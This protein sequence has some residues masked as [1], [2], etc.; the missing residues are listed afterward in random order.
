MMPVAQ[1]A[2]VAWHTNEEGHRLES[3]AAEGS[4]R[5]LIHVRRDADLRELCTL[6]ADAGFRVDCS[7]TERVD[8]IHSS[9]LATGPSLT[10]TSPHRS[11]IPPLHDLLILDQVSALAGL[12]SV[13]TR[14]SS[15]YLDS[16][17]PVLFITADPNARL[18]GLANGANACLVR[19]FSPEELLAQVRALLRLKEAHNRLSE[20][21][22]E[23]HRANKR[24][25][26]A[27]R[28]IDEELELARRIQQSM[29]PKS[30]PSL[31]PAKFA[32]YYHPCGRVGGDFY[33]V[34]RLDEDHLG[35]Y[36]A[37][38][39]GHGIPAALLTIFLKKAIQAKEIVGTHYRLLP[40]GEV[41][42]RLNREMI[43]LALAESPFLTM[44]YALYD[45]RDSTV[46]FSRAGHP[47]PLYLPSS[48]ELEFWALHGTLLGVFETEFAVE[49]RRMNPGDKLLLYTDGIETNDETENRQGAL[50]LLAAAAKHRHRPIAELITQLSRELFVE[51]K[52]ADD[53]TLLGMEVGLQ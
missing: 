24:L 17:V 46:S 32:V 44:I 53:L 26:H 28:Q 11:T 38:V 5:I 15:A 35:F 6:L 19:P 49:K 37:D 18:D 36:V 25:T 22:D 23:F 34:T 40:P 4:Y 29:L 21:T 8:S 20:K 7:R 50:R 3:M 13:A 52:Q 16:L 43:Q 45:R 9:Q 31:P 41:L 47:P 51:G 12:R 42:V 39:M 10:A 1:S 2:L 33:D 14:L 27:Y 30:F 48:G